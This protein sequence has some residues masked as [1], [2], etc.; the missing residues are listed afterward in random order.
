MRLSKINFISNDKDLSVFYLYRY[1]DGTKEVVTPY[2]PE[3]PGTPYEICGYRLVASPNKV[4]TKDNKKFYTV[5]AIEIDDLQ[6][7]IEIDNPYF[8]S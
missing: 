7:W 2:I 4:V 5:V 1:T 6:N 8:R 3:D